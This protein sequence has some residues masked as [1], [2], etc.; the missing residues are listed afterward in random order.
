MFSS[1][2]LQEIINLSLKED[3]GSGDITSELTIPANKT[4]VAEIISRQSGVVA[5]LEIAGKVFKIVDAGL[6]FLAFVSDGEEVGQ[7][8]VVAKVAG[9]LRSIV[10][11]E[12][13][14]LNFLQHISGIATLTNSWVRLIE[15]Y[16]AQL[17]DT[18][19]TTPGLRQL[20]K[21]A[22]VVG[23]GRNHRKG[24]DGGV[25]IK[26]NHIAAAG[27]IEEAVNR[28]KKAAPV[29][30][31]VEV[32]AT[33]LEQLTEALQ[34]GAELIML[35]NMDTAEMQQAVEINDGQAC[36]EASGNITGER[37]QEIAATGVD[38]ISCGALTHSVPAMDYSLLIVWDTGTGPL[39]R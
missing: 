14:A 13:T 27:G 26:E 9:N 3:L 23:G 8:E 30:L 12:R 7:G 2:W 16:P 37:L 21:Y 17:V 28:A 36:L 25:L 33:N 39:S 1:P 15:G 22:V 29:T 38:Y 18:R 19:K 20:E 10:T 24:L 35:D 6:D 4:G 11:A 32:E 5:G 34:A 31:R